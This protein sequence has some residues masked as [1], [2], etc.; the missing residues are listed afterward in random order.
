M[1]YTLATVDGVVLWREDIFATYDEAEVARAAYPE[2]GKEIVVVTTEQ[3]HEL[4][5]MRQELYAELDRAKA[6]IGTA[7]TAKILGSSA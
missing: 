7:R 3:A 1:S 5:A 4:N 6:L 2:S